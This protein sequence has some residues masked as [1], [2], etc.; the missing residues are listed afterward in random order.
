MSNDVDE[1]VCAGDG[2]EVPEAREASD[3]HQR[4]IA[5]ADQAGKL[6]ISGETKTPRALQNPEHPTDTVRMLHYTTHVP[7]PDW[8]PFC[9]TSRARCS[10]HRGVAVNKTADTLPKF[11]SDHMFIRTVADSKTEPCITLVETRSGAADQLHVRKV[12]TRP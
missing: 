6:G 2:D 5:D 11:H 4:V 1:E 9:L 10:P 12:D 3:G 7:F 8:C